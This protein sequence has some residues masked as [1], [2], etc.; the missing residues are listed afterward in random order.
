M[1]PHLTYL[2]QRGQEVLRPLQ[3]NARE[4]LIGQ[5][6]WQQFPDLVGTPLE[7]NC[8]RAMEAQVTVDFEVFYSPLDKWFDIRAYPSRDGLAI[9]LQDISKRKEAETQLRQQ[10][11]W[12]QVTLSSIG[13]AVITTDTQGKVTF[14]NPV[15]ERMT[16][17]KS[18]EAAGRPLQG[19]FEI[20]NE[21]TRQP[22]ENPVATV[23]REGTIV[24]LANHTA[25]IAKDRTETAIE[26]SAAPIRDTL[27]NISG[28]VM[29]FHDVT[30][31]RRAE[32]ALRENEE[33]LR[34]TFSQAAVGIA[35]AGLDG[36][37]IELNRKFSD[38]LGY[39]PSEL[40]HRTFLALTHPDDLAQTQ[41][42]V[43]RLLAGEVAEYVQEKRYIRKDGALVWSLT[44]VTLLK[45]ADGR[46]QR[47]IGVIEDVSARKHAEEAV[48]EGTERLQLAL[49][50]G[51]MGDWSWDAATD[52]VFLGSQAAEI[53]GL[54]PEQ[55]ITWA[56]M[57]RLLHPTDA[58]AARKALEEALAGRT[59]YNS[60]YRLNRP[61]G[62]QR[63]IAA[64]GRGVY[65]K[66]GS[67]LGMTGVVQDISERKY[68][69]E[70]LRDETRI[71]ELLNKTGTTLASKLDL[72][73]LLQAVTDAATQ[74][75]GAKIGAFFYTPVDE[76]SAS[77]PPSTLSGAPRDAFQKLGY[78]RAKALFGP[79]FRG[80]G[81][82]RCAD[83]LKDPRYEEREPRKIAGPPP[84]RSYLAVSVVSRSGEVI[85][86]LFFGH[87]ELGMFTERT[88]RIIIG[89]AA[90]AAV[91]IDNAR[92]YEAAQ[93]AAEERERLLDSER[94]A[95]AEAERMSEMKDEFLANLSHEL[96]TPL[97][98]TLGW[99]QVLRGRTTDAAAV[100]LG[101]QTIER[102][103][104]VQTQL[105]ED[106]LDMSR[107][108]SGKVRL[109]V[110]PLEPASFIEAAIETIRFGA[111]AKG[112][113]LDALLDHAAGPVSGDPNRLQ[114]VIWNLPSNAI[115]F[116]PKDGK[117]RVLLE[118]VDSHI[119]ISVADTGIGIKS[120][121]I[122]HVF[123]R[124]RQADAS[125]TRRYGGLGLG[126]S[127]VK[128]LVELHG[129]TVRVSSGGEGCG[130]TFVVRLPLTVVHGSPYNE[131]PQH[132]KTAKT[133]S[134][135][136]KRL[137]LAG[138][139]V[140]VVDDEVDA[141]NL[142]ERVL[143]D[144]DAE[145]FTAGTADEALL[146]I[147][148][149]RPH[150]LVSDIGMPEVDGFEFI[151]RV[152]ALGEARGGKIPA[153]AL[154]AFARSEDRTRALRAGFLVHV[155]KPVEPS[156][157]V[158]TVASVAGRTGEVM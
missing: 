7:K 55:P 141:R 89:V 142:I 127:I 158:A 140:L 19:V 27:G 39:S 22:V 122:D 20:V 21:A 28:A 82:I 42:N 101:L 37:F 75:S 8:R 128:H 110:Q 4:V 45:D 30:A 139:K 152:R 62:G 123:E 92:L 11:E 138:V 1:A 153:I 156:E 54:L 40:Q 125:T 121:F 149:E 44:T 17:W 36:G 148:R 48:R 46:P 120:E 24:A 38:I 3:N 119:E 79:T 105:I 111:D 97:Q 96:R 107:I 41:T 112:I 13:D 6:L 124:F 133:L 34:A 43:R 85:G 106:L 50:A 33:R 60:E 136:L 63:W 143:A 69:E 129:G 113:R 155:T 78:P 118:R 14:L 59:D 135:D 130:S 35:V 76:Q 134:V 150:V 25:L 18:A 32:N 147:E 157:W 64:S 94:F 84:V 10:R 87:P 56:E 104:R 26:D 86:G 100:N 90:Q 80:E 151:K 81:P 2:N 52:R 91:V 23:L 68:A 67:V 103:A 132:P 126:L 108:T 154:T 145:V 53:F 77:Y 95:R 131:V 83:V 98:S 9:Y 99:A 65:A 31:R 93:K 137:D 88:E 109:D 144:C 116:T 114:Q 61:S 15:A 117:V 51:H 146:F 57:R 5:N 29:V 102:S 74:L 47:F 49:S 16:G 66:D 72:P 12:F 71:L 73:T 115:Q 58:E 70:A